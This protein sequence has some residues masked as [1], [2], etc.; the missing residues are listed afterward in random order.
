MIAA[1]AAL[2]LAGEPP[3]VASVTPAPLPLGATAQVTGTGFVAG[4]TA[5][6]IGD[7]P[8]KV[9]QVEEA[10]LVLSVV[11]VTPVGPAKLTVTTPYG[12]A[13]TDVVVAPAPPKLTS[14]V[15]SPL[16]M[17]KPATVLGSGLDT[18]ASLT[19]GG[20]A[21][22]PTEQTALVL[23]FE[24]PVSA[25]LAGAQVLAVTG[26]A[27]DDALDVT[28]LPPSPSVDTVTPNPAR[29]GDLVT[30][31]GPIVGGPVTVTIGDLA[32]TILSVE[33]GA[34]RAQIPPKLD[35]GAWPVTLAALGEVSAPAGPLYVTAAD[36]E[37]PSV[38]AVVPATVVAGGFVWIVGANMPGVTAAEGLT[39]AEDA[40]D[41]R[42]CR[43]IAPT[44]PGAVA[45]ALVGPHGAD[46]FHVVVAA[47]DGAPM[48]VLESALPNP[49][50]RGAAL[51]LKGQGLLG[52]TEVYV[53]GVAQTIDLVEP[54]AVHV[55]VALTTPKGSEPAFVAGKSG[56]LAVPVVVLDAIPEP[57]SEDAGLPPA[58]EAAPEPATD[59]PTADSGIV[60]DTPT[61]TLSSSGG[62]CAASGPGT[63]A[64]WGLV[65]LLAAL[66]I[67][68]RRLG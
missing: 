20:V 6:A 31:G 33:T 51:V 54:G 1:L 5:V 47:S 40:C 30:I 32:A 25:V 28:V 26:P 38:A 2:L 43:L 58:P 59:E 13:S 4:K 21:C 18:V 10:S 44:E 52:V 48:P 64:A 9:V 49:V 36:A 7:V 68:R 37:R 16:R 63:S 35:P 34:V 42:A 11:P 50:A 60:A 24:V 45:G 53:G 23:A 8:Q 55:T 27:G 19:L 67:R 3:T 17:G 39:L 29:Q 46:T 66:A 61:A 15:P 56:S 41:E 12:Q 57:P 14:V 22:T 62:G 65:L